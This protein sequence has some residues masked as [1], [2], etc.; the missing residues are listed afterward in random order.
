MPRL[1]RQW[2]QRE[3]PRS[4]DQTASALSVNL[5]RLASAGLLALENEGFE[6]D[7][8]SQRLDV[9][10]HFVIFG[11]HLIDRQTEAQLPLEERTALLTALVKHLAALMQDNREESDGPGAHATGFVDQFNHWSQRYGDCGWSAQG[12][13]GFTLYRELGDAV[14]ASMGA[15]DQQWIATYVI[16]REAPKFAKALKQSLR[17]LV[18]AAPGLQKR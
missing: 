4:A 12:G 16:E 1:S 7:D 17:G 2:N 9:I 18:A 3:T 14:A 10:G 6:T 15:H 13:P 5:W 8:W 11:A